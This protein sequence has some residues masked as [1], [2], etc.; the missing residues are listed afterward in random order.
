M[1]S[2]AELQLEFAR[3]SHRTVFRCPRQDPPWKIVRGFTLEHGESLVHLNNVSGGIFGGDA[4]KLAVQVHPGAEAQIT[5][6]GATRIYRPRPEA[7]EAM[8]VSEFK[9]GR[10]ALL[11][12][13]PDALIP[14]R[15]SRAFQR[16]SYSLDEGATL[17]FWETV[18]PGRTASG[19]RFDYERLKLAT[20]ID[21]QGRPVFRDRL[22]LEPANSPIQSPARF[23]GCGYLVT[24]LAMRAGLTAAEQRTLEQSLE[25]VVYDADF[26][27]ETPPEGERRTSH[28]G[29]TTLPAHGVLVR[30][31]TDSA[32]RIPAMLQTLW[33]QAK[34]YLCGRIAIAPRKTY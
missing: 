1:N 3:Q 25:A 22:M 31:I 29:V 28:W 19:E 6:T 16:T 15:S 5:T 17:F 32:V 34:Y 9:V 11:E 18:A 10:D 26:Q 23:G 21:V 30:G 20:E 13:L 33:S 4:L 12:Y 2:E 14:F 8:L 27:S 24:F 7:A